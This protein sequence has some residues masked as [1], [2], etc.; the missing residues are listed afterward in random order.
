[1]YTLAVHKHTTRRRA[2]VGV[3]VAVTMTVLLGMAAL[4]I[5]LSMLYNIRADLQRSAD[6][7]ALAATWELLDDDVLTGSPFKAEEIAAARQAA[8]DYVDY[9]PSLGESLSIDP[10]YAN[11]TDGDVVIGF[12][13]SPAAPVQSM[14]YDDPDQF[15]TVLVRVRRDSE[16]NGS[17]KLFFAGILGKSESNL[18]AAAVASLQDGVVGFRA[19]PGGPNSKLI[20]LALH[21]DAWE[22][23]LDGTQTVGDNYG[24]DNDTKT[25]VPFGDGLAELNIYPGGGAGQLSP[26]NFGTVDIGSDSNSTADVARQIREGVNASDFAYLGGELKLGV[27]G[28][29]DLNG[30]TGISAGFKDDLESIIGQARV[31]LL[32]DNVEGPG[33]NAVFTIV[34]FAGIRIVNVNLTG[35]PASREVRIQPAHVIDPTALTGSEDENSYF[36]YQPV[37]LI[38]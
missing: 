38:Y 32:F 3:F 27:D 10:N 5:D 21:V 22:A 11:I 16:H 15:N 9:N 25:V 28:T 26:G 35:P 4:A 1:M 2:A 36:V 34:G 31:V 14:S 20:P 8:V 12:L 24:Y 37:Q 30:D 13:P 23:L 7:A 17:I 29:V 19:P 6:A 18:A 33:N